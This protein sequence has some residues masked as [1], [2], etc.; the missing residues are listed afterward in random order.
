MPVHM[1]GKNGILS[2][3]IAAGIWLT[4]A[5]PAWS[6]AGGFLD[7]GSGT[8][9]VGGEA[10]TGVVRVAPSFYLVTPDILLRADAEYADHTQRSWQTKGIISG[11]A[12]RSLFGVLE[13]SI[14]ARGG[15]SR[16][17][18]G[19]TAGSWLGETKIQLGD[20]FGGLAIAAGA[21]QT[22]T[23]EGTQPMSRIEAGGW[24]RFGGFDLG[25]WVRRTG[26]TAPGASAGPGRD[27]SPV[28]T[29]DLGG[30]TRRTVQDYYTDADLSFGWKRGNFAL[31]VGVGRRFGKPAVEFNSWSLQALYQL[32]SRFALVGSTGEF[33]V[34][35]ISGLPAGRFTTLSMRV[36]LRKDDPAAGLG[37]MAPRR[38]GIGGF[39]ATASDGGLYLI[40]VVVPRAQT[41]EL[42]GSFND[43]LPVP[44]VP[45]DEDRW[46]LR[47]ALPAGMH[48]VNVRVDGGDWTVPP[49][50]TSMDDGLGARVGVFVIE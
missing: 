22:L 25:L 38:G 5:G 14:G 16:T 24:G 11:S 47:M 33:P 18:W 39:E 30:N 1:S 50:L 20:A 41:V 46:V 12:R 48:E 8:M 43:W 44:L 9:R 36:S 10:P 17:S 7:T 49:G 19:R 26:V 28:D 15:W 29:M 35:V 4:S 23:R 3:T 13:A 37:E 31:T 2:L 6:Q 21:G 40:T 45:D 32:N 34:D 42:M 27:G